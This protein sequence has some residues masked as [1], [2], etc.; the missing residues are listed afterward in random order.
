MTQS[1]QPI[2]NWQRHLISWPTRI[3]YIQKNRSNLYD[4]KFIVGPEQIIFHAH[5][6]IFAIASP[7]FENLFYFTETETKD[8]IVLAETK[9]ET[10]QEFMNFIYFGKLDL[11]SAN[12]I[13][14]YRLSKLYLIT[15]LTD[16]CQSFMEKVINNENVLNF[17]ELTNDFDLQILER[18]CLKKIGEN[19]I[20]L[21]KS[22]GFLENSRKSLEKIVKCESLSCKEIGIFDAVNEWTENSCVKNQLEA[23][24][25]NKR[26]AAGD[27]VKQIRYETMSLE[28]FG[29]CSTGNTFLTKTEI[30]EIFQ[31][32]A[33][34][35]VIPNKRIGQISYQKCFRFPG[36]HSKNFTIKNNKILSALDFTVN[37]SIYLC[38]VGI[39]GTT[40]N[41]DEDKNY[42]HLIVSNKETVIGNYFKTLKYDSSKQIYELYF[43]DP[44]L[45]EPI[46]K[47]DFSMIKR[48]DD[49]LKNLKGINGKAKLEEN[50]VI[51]EISECSPNRTDNSETVTEGVIASFIFKRN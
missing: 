46:K 51:F 38:G 31:K 24:S 25:E 42:L 2:T 32:L 4:F 33:S 5:K 27:I 37:Q 14:I 23:T 44:L 28:E 26:M 20:E 39:Y 48:C 45:I 13:E 30:I 40:T 3:A 9:P 12:V 16:E 1:N 22:S 34:K 35:N 19:S 6:L 8:E 7:E 11:T 47:Y 50:G 18:N 49:D 17:L 36:G 41:I 21:L 43:D 29:K 15:Q 10:F